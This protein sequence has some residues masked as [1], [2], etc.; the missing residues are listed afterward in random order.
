MSN[1]VPEASQVV[2][3]INNE[4]YSGKLYLKKKK[5]K[6]EESDE[7]LATGP[8]HTEIPLPWTVLNNVGL[9]L[10]PESGRFPFSFMNFVKIK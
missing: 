7:E 10:V 1:F 2:V 9:V 8:F 6:L 4:R 5:G 3:A